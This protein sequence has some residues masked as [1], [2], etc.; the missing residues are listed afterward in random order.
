MLINGLLYNSEAW[1][2][3]N[4]HHVDELE[5]IDRLLLRRILRVPISTP[6]ESLYLELGLLPI[7]YIIRCRRVLFLQYML[8]LDVNGMLY[9]FLSVQWTHPS[10]NDWTITVKNDLEVLGIKMSLFQIQNMSTDRFKQ[11]ITSS[12]R[13]L[14]LS[15]LITIQKTHSKLSRLNYS[16]LNMQPYFND[17]T[18]DARSLFLYRTRMV[19]V[20]SNCVY[21]KSLNPV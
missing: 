13:N 20:Y 19:R 8:Q 17:A 16:E 2:N 4:N 14:A 1:Y 12:S 7:S 3:V 10:R 11:L 9:K 18:I 5:K 21:Q 15:E 6:K